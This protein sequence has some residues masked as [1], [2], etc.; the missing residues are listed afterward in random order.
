MP[1]NIFA[2]LDQFLSQQPE[3]DFKESCRVLVKRTGF[4]RLA[5]KIDWNGAAEV[6]CANLIGAVAEEGQASLVEFLGSLENL[7]KLGVEDRERLCELRAA[8]AALSPVE[9]DEIFLGQAHP[10]PSFMAESP[11]ANFVARPA[12][13][14]AA[15][16]ALL[17]GDNGGAGAAALTTAL[18][19]A[20]GFGK[21][22]LA[23]WLCAQEAVR[24]ISP[25]GVLWVTLGEKPNILGWLAEIHYTLTGE[26]PNFVD[27]EPAAAALENLLNNRH[28]LLVIDDVWNSAHLQPF[29]RGG[30][31]C[32]RL[33]TTRNSDILPPDCCKIEVDAM[34]QKEAVELLGAGLPVDGQQE[35]LG[36]L[37]ARLGEW[38]LL[39]NL[40]NGALRNRI[41][42]GQPVYQ[43]LASIDQT[44]AK[45][46]LT[47]FDARDA[48][49]RE[50][51]VRLTI[52][53]SLERLTAAEQTRYLELAV[54]PED[55][56]VPLAAVAGL[57]AHTGNLEAFECED[58]YLRMHSLSLLLDLNLE[59]Q[60]LRLHD[61]MRAYLIGEAAAA[62]PALHGQ[63]VDAYTASLPA[64]PSTDPA[65]SSPVVGGPSS[66]VALA[67]VG[68]PSSIVW[69]SGPDDGYYFQFL[70]YHLA[71]ARREVELE[72][73]L[74]NFVWLL[75][76]L[77]VTGKPQGLVDDYERLRDAGAFGEEWRLIQGALRLSAHVL[78]GGPE[79]LAAQLT[80]R[81]L[82]FGGQGQ[83]LI[84]GL[85]A[86]ARAWSAPA[87][88]RPLIPC[89]E[90]P[91][92]SLLRTLEG[93][94]GMVLAVAAAEVEGRACTLSGSWDN[95]LK[96]W[97]LS[98]GT[99]L[100]TLEGHTRGVNAVAA[101]EVEGRACALSGAVDGTLKLWDLSSGALLRTLE[102]H[103]G[104]VNAVAAAEVKRRACALSGS[105][106]HTLKL[107]D[108]S[109]AA[110]E[111]SAP[112]LRTLEGHTGAVNAVATAEVEGRT[113][114]LSGSDDRT[115]KLWDLSSGTLLRTLEGHTGMVLAVAAAE[116]EGRA[117]AL[118]GS[119]DGT[120]K[121]WDLSSGTLLRTL[122][123]HEDWVRAVAAAEVEGRAC[124]LSGAVDGTLK[125]WDLSSGALLR[126]LEGHT[127]GVNAVAAAQVEGRACALSGS[128]DHT[129]KLWDISFLNAGLSSA[130][131]ENSAPLLRTLEGHTGMV[132]AVAAA[133]V[134]GRACALSGSWDNT[135]KLWDLSSGTLLR[136]L[137]GYTTIV[138]AVA[139]AEVEGRT[140]ALSGSEGGTLKLWDLS[141]GALLRTLQGHTGSVWAVAGVKLEGRACALSGSEDGTLKLWDLSSG[142]LLRA[143]E[144]STN[145]A[146]AVAAAEVEG[147]TC[148]LSGLED[149]TLRLWDLSSGAL[150]RTLQ[151]HTDVVTA[152]VAVEVE[153]RAC[154][155][156]GSWDNTLK[157][158]DISSL[159]ASPSSG[160]LLRTLQGHTGRVTA[161]A[162]AGVEGRACALSGAVDGTLKLWDL[163]SGACLATFRADAPIY[164]CA[165][166][167]DG[168]TFIAGDHAGRVIFLCLEGSL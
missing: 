88:L 119:F 22:T 13:S 149:H 133:E 154:A 131:L 51:A 26:R 19:G 106:D 10:S 7:L 114:A 55:L 52:G 24:A 139:A 141:S 140:C 126:T 166:A 57:W 85:L 101:A 130:A 74:G 54:F 127:G 79:Q 31:N 33:I 105:E 125:L 9:F 71:Q 90:A 53:V 160:A 118:S 16:A 157:L 84:E 155:L 86:Q 158:W 8:I 95:T 36:R 109:S 107:W 145:W 43:A 6:F 75:R 42:R 40:A 46:G 161:V 97:E 47:A 11:P 108:L 23:R 134:E 91:G 147:R 1:K 5:R 112:L 153:G 15:L 115:L 28:C 29:L 70:P 59:R 61:V 122:E 117:C 92:G 89:L 4:E 121:L 21:T 82:G 120:L 17:A 63:L 116:V 38:P 113:C 94:T 159:N 156:S 64:S 45:R 138:T 152:V 165:I 14:Q 163:S 72:D 103:T 148:A 142:A 104:A 27:V 93:H 60:T 167:P 132:L 67:V 102:G 100:R 128:E 20:G 164:S 98:S 162:A 62:L 37:A 150:L 129:L 41:E 66:V 99:L 32:R 111:N 168:R 77:Q 146:R 39:L 12:E 49:A 3:F 96:L 30:P 83:R 80:G 137:E 143:L 124:A 136:T 48:A 50:Q 18:R 44:L 73:L 76:K 135:L 2:D 144:R 87:W 110:L 34:R 25:D 56:D 65:A 58:L 35:A 69:S 68:S 151:G 81:L 123:G 78:R